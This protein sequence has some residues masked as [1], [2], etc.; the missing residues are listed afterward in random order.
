L[1][2]TITLTATVPGTWTFVYAADATTVISLNNDGVNAL[3]SNNYALAIEKFKAALKLDPGYQLA[4]DNL[5][6]AHNNYGLQLRNTPKE[7][8]KQFHEALYLNRSN[9]TTLQNVEGII[10]IMGKDP[11]SFKDRVDL[12][13]QA[14]QPPNPDFIGAIIEYSEAL[15]IKDDPKVHTK[16]G[17][18][19]RVRDE[20][21]KA[22]A[23]FQAAA[24]LA[25]GAEIEIKLGQA[26]QA[27]KDIP[28][29]IVCYGKAIGFKSDDPEVQDALVA[30]WEEALRE[31]P[32]APENHVGLGQAFQYRGDFGQAQQ[33]YT[34]AI[35]FSPGKQ[36]ATAQRLLAALPAAKA[37]AAVSKHINAG[38]DLQT[39]KQ[40]EPALAE[41]KLAAQADPKNDAVWVNIG[42]VY[43]AMDKYDD[44]LTS[45]NQAL[46]I[47]PGNQAAQQGVSTASAARKDKII[48]TQYK[49]GGD[50][51]KAGKYQE[52]MMAFQEVLKYNPNDPATHFSLGATYQQMKNWDGAKSEYQLAINLD[53]KNKDYP[54]ALA[55]AKVAQAAPIIEAAVQKHKAKDYPGAIAL[56]TQAL[57][58]TPDNASLLYNIASAEYARQEYHR[59]RDAY[60]KAYDLDKK[61]QINDLY[62]IAA[63]D[64]NFGNGEDARSGYQKYL[65]LA[66]TGTYVAAAKDRC[67]A[68]NKN[69]KDTQK[70][71][72]DAE[73]AQDKT[74]DD[75]YQAAINFQ[76]A[77]Q[78]DQAIESY[79]KA[80]AIHPD[81]A[82]YNYSI[83]TC[84]Q[85][86]QD[87]ASAITYYNK[88]LA[89]EPGNKDFKNV[90]KEA[91]ELSVGPLVD[92]AAEK[93]AKG[94]NAGA[95]E[96]YKQV[97]VKTPQ[98]ARVMTNIA[99]ALQATDKFQEA[100]EWYQ[101]AYDLDNKNE[102]GDLFWMAK[103]DENFGNGNKAY[104]EYQQYLHQ[105]AK[106]QYAGD[107]QDAS[108]RLASNVANTVK[109]QTT[110]QVA[111]ARAAA[112]AYDAGVKAQ[113]ATPANNDEA[114]AKYLVAIAKAPKEDAYVYAL[115]TAYQAKGD[116]VNAVIQYQLAIKMKPTNKDYPKILA[117]AKA[118]QSG[119]IM[120]EAIKKQTAGDLPGA[121]KLYQEA[122]QADPSYAHGWTNLASAYQQMEDWVH[123]R[124]AFKKAVDLDPK[125]EA[126]NWYYI[127]L[128]DE[129]AGAAPLAISDYERYV[130][131]LPK[132]DYAGNANQRILNLRSHPADVQKMVTK[133]E[134]AKQGE[135]Q[136]AY[137][138][139]VKLQTDNKLDEAIE[140]YKKAIAASPNEPSYYYSM[141]TAYQGKNDPASLDLAI[142]NYR[143]AQKMNP[144]EAAYKQVLTAAL[145][146]KAAPLVQSAITKQT[147][148]PK[149]DLVGAIADYEAALRI[150]DDADTYK[151]LGTAYQGNNNFA[152]AVKVYEKAFQLDPKNQAE[153]LYYLG[154]CYEQ[155]K[156]IPQAKAAY[157][158]YLKAAPAGQFANDAKGRIKELTKK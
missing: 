4:R 42:T 35:R 10:K 131:A 138:A 147:A 144:K 17:D 122:L 15:K 111:D 3:K 98:N 54:K 21:D 155:L 46:K 99:I 22:I 102:V 16:L 39:R 158:R 105:A 85:Q 25:D 93:Q 68:L 36:N 53:P 154:T 72:S 66:P 58:L 94:D 63:I 48:E 124:E 139:A 33:E 73:L 132:G 118:L 157:E 9:P 113:T 156:N 128:L 57:A 137:D 91:T 107:A 121:I 100:R 110:T 34:Q 117:A 80:L 133:A 152:Q 43:Q 23:E 104:Q 27:K 145:A 69:I 8:L 71:K 112:E 151:N 148:T 6:I 40:Y 24:K 77:K 127:A 19:Y 37:A 49:N 92:Q 18:V 30:G 65:A 20:N 109:L 150:S 56:Y 1:A 141:G 146:A 59:A 126:A 78:F 14:R 116:L 125:N 95:I 62:F 74:A 31:N 28:N 87:Y 120:D 88:A 51:F 38:V 84:Y 119:G 76:K 153:A 32:L 97:L 135:A 108:K 101:K 52:A 123:A 44:A 83:G 45:Y 2:C 81:N 89:K 29:A 13:D 26:F 106:G 75:A 64:E 60:A 5:A 67:T 11:H 61:G 86:K 114:V 149:P 82:D 103:I 115:G 50:L 41:Y 140:Q 47:N 143:K 130:K 7:A 129:N 142:E 90:L 12:G 79:Q 55:G 134:S 70:I 136:T 96:M